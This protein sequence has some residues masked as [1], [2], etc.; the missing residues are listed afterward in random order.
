MEDAI[1]RE[2]GYEQGQRIAERV[3]GGGEEGGGGLDIVCPL[4]KAVCF[5]AGGARQH[6]TSGMIGF[7][8]RLTTT[9]TTAA[10]A[11]PLMGGGDGG[12]KTHSYVLFAT[13]KVFRV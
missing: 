5:L 2:K 12:D 1:D 7:L 9:P 10:P 4:A 3:G 13:A 11:S 8:G 6:A